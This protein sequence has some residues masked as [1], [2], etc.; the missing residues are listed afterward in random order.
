MYYVIVAY[1]REQSL[2][3]R[4]RARPEHV[5]RLQALRDQGRLLTAGPCPIID[6]EDPGE[7]GF[8]G[9][10]IIAEFD[11]LQTAQDWAD[12]DPYRVSGVYEKTE[13]RPFK[14]VF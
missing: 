4:M 14:L 9:S 5:A 8:S 11:S 6:S 3:D 2:Q 7:S 13:V 1:D 12:S 10:V